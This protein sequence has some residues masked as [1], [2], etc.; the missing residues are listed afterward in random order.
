M[1]SRAH[2]WVYR[3]ASD[4]ALNFFERNR[5][6]DCERGLARRLVQAGT[7]AILRRYFRVAQD[8]RVVGRQ[9]LPAQG[10]F[11]IVCNHSS[12]FDALALAASVPRRC[13]TQVSLLAAG[14]TFFSSRTRAAFASI[15][16]NA[17][18]VWR[19]ACGS[20]ALGTLRGRLE[21]VDEEDRVGPIMVL[22]PEGTRS[23]SGKIARFKAG[24]GALVAGTR[25]PVVPCFLSGAHEAWPAGRKLPQRGSLTLSIGPALTFEDQLNERSGWR[26]V[27]AKLEEQVRALAEA[28]SKRPL[29]ESSPM[30]ALRVV[31]RHVAR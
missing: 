24:V 26:T 17:R 11:V 2:Q 21:S 1:P 5:S 30:G 28:P 9:N 23:R 13:A 19:G 10:P 12:H 7:W 4:L 18:P 31:G 25:V 22:F 20:K 14:D 15:V 27:A 16:L 8:L 29:P 3:P 6:L